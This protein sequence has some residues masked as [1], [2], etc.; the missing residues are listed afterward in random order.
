[1]FR[2]EYDLSCRNDRSKMHSYISY[3]WDKARWGTASHIP[4][5]ITEKQ[6]IIYPAHLGAREDV[7][8]SKQLQYNQ[9]RR[10]PKEKPLGSLMLRTCF[11]APIVIPI[12]FN[13]D[14][15]SAISPVRQPI[16]SV[17]QFT[18]S[19]SSMLLPQVKGCNS[20]PGIATQ[21]FAEDVLLSLVIS[22][23][24]CPV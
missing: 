1:M 15:D 6:F 20:T 18:P 17:P 4:R 22:G 14:R 12:R 11:R 23:R 2:G 10:P 9:R 24:P 19:G 5:K 7:C 21:H 3:K 8:L 16:S 13:G